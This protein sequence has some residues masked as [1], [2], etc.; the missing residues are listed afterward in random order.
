M[1][2]R[3]TWRAC[4][5]LFRIRMAEGLQYRAA[6][7]SGVLVS[8]FWGLIE[9]AL[10]AVFFTYGEKASWNTGG[11]TLAQAISYVW[12]AQ[13]LFIFQSTN[14]DGEILGKIKNGDVALELCRPLGLYAHW[15]VKSA[16]GK[17]G[18]GWVRSVLTV[19][20]GALM[21]AALR[22][23]PPGSAAGLAAAMLST[24]LAFMLCSTFAMMVTSLRLNVT[25]GDG[26]TYMILLISSVLSGTYLPLRLWPDFM[27]PFLAVQ[28]FGGFADIPI[29]LYI[30]T[31]QPE[32]AL[33]RLGLQLAWTL[34]FTA[35]GKWIMDQRL[36][37]I[38][39]QGG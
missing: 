23:G 39:V 36:K 5:S 21:P 38:I 35:A 13:G 2:L 16:A 10:L 3:Q 34:L 37:T 15:L 30:G 18:F 14:M 29:Q 9:C 22:L 28:P 19:A 1:S 11:M 8:V 27:Q 17:L 6:A 24:V 7:L 20:A 26:P 4:F 25:W 32:A 33:P 12:L 31:L